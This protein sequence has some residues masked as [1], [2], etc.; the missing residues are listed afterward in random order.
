MAEPKEYFLSDGSKRYL[1]QYRDNNRHL[2]T[3]RGFKTKRDARAWLRDTLVAL[4]RHEYV[5]A[6]SSRATVAMLGPGW[7]DGKRV[8]KPS[9]YAP[10]EAAWRNYVLPRWGNRSIG[11]IRKSEVQQWVTEISKGTPET[12][13]KSSTVVLRAYGVLA[14][15]LDSAV[16]DR[17]LSIN[18][19]RGVDL[20]RK[21]SKSKTYLSHEQVRELADAS[22]YPAIIYLMAYTGL[23]WGEVCGLRVKNVN[24]LKRRISIEENAVRVQGVI[25]VGTPKTHERRT[26]PVPQFLLPLISEAAQGKEPRE[27]LF[28]GE[29]GGYMAE[30]RAGG[31]NRSWF[32]QAL[33]DSGVPRV[34]PHDLR[35]TA[36]SLAVQSG[37][38]VKVLQKMLGHASAA[39]TLDTYADLFDEDLD[40]VAA[41]MNA[42]RL[43]NVVKM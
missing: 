4:E 25:H 32:A 18:P 14:G 7:L 27:I 10:L 12:R 17:M 40:D 22:K 5:S 33:R 30:P 28:P 39:M 19:A 8:L 24:F 20:P 13:A 41:A 23:R 36:A 38:N 35:H 16:S 1:V 31:G 11:T 29:G 15:I 34:T 26:V 42:A 2:T 37:A 9:S 43:T 21:T 3:K 6:T